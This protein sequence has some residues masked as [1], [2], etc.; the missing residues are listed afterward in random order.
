MHAHLQRVAT[1]HA[2]IDTHVRC[3]QRQ[4]R[5]QCGSLTSQYYVTERGSIQHLASCHLYEARS[6]Y[7]NEFSIRVNF[8]R[9]LCGNWKSAN[10]SVNFDTPKRFSV[11]WSILYVGMPHHHHEVKLHSADDV[12]TN[13]GAHCRR[14]L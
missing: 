2:L 8:A 5:L 6:K 12:T 11:K 1:S 14:R 7:R 9:N 3:M 13:Q 10:L 4:Q